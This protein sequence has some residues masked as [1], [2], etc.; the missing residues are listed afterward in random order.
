VLAP[1]PLQG[2]RV[3]AA[4]AALD[5]LA[6]DL[7]PAVRLLRFAPDE[8]FVIGVGPGDIHVDDPDAIVEPESGF[9]AVT[10]DR[11]LVARH[12][13]WHLPDAVPDRP[14]EPAQGAI[15]GVPAQGAIAGVPAKITWR[16]DGRASV[17]THGA[18]VADLV[19]RL[20]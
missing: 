8:A 18:Y 1:E 17:V 19:E 9:V 14:T 13:D 2:V 3:V 11:A 7:L 10:V 4:P 5:A 16:S 12:T 6:A 20:R 15:A